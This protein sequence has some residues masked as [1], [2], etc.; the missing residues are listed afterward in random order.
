MICRV[1]AML[2]RQLR[3]LYGGGRTT[4][5]VVAA[6]GSTGA[7]RP[8]AIAA[9]PLNGVCGSNNCSFHHR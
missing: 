2:I 6:A 1:V 7:R 3:H 9:V 8:N 5:V 4:V